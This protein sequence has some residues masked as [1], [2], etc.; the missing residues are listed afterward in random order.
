[1][2]YDEIPDDQVFITDG[3]PIYNADQLFYHING[4]AFELHQVIGIKNKYVESKKWRLHKLRE[5]GSTGP[6][7]R[8]TT[9]PTDTMDLKVL[10]VTW[11][12]MWHSI[13]SSEDIPRLA[14]ACLWMNICSMTA[15]SCMRNGS[16]SSR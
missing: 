1:M 3:N 15:R 8:T 2:H 7:S 14:A 12:S 4:T 11:F 9:E 6:T 16:S 5:E 10:T 13:I